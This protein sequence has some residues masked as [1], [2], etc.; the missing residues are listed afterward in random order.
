M[1]YYELAFTIMMG[2]DLFV[3]ETMVHREMT[4]SSRSSVY[5]AFV[6]FCIVHHYIII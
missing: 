3:Y 2:V 5:F 1:G 6:Y 4:E